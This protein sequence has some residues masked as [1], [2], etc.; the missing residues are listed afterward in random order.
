M[1]PALLLGERGS[2][3]EGLALEGKRRPQQ[4]LG[5]FNSSS[6]SKEESCQGAETPAEMLVGRDPGA[7]LPSAEMM[8]Q[9]FQL[10]VKQAAAFG[11]GFASTPLLQL[12]PCKPSLRCFSPREALRWGC[13]FRAW[14]PCE[15]RGFGVPAPTARSCGVRCW[16]DVG[17]KRSRVQGLAGHGQPGVRCSSTDCHQHQP[18]SAWG[19]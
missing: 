3:A 19:F 1:W 2:G 16:G 10:L 12:F 13:Q 8:L 5:E 15:G 6:G 17:I 11:R 7:P 18:S 14:C 9:T 4:R